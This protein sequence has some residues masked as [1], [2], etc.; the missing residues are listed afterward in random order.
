MEGG[1]F[2]VS[3]TVVLRCDSAVAGELRLSG[4]WNASE[5]AVVPVQLP[6]GEHQLVINLTA[7]DPQLWWPVNMG[8]QYLY[9]VTLEGVFGSQFVQVNRTLGFRV[10]HLATSTGHATPTMFFRVNGQIAL[11]R[12]R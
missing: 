2:L 3:A 12:G 9:N 7:H 6:V 11:A 10:V 1:D 4:D 8:D 5:P